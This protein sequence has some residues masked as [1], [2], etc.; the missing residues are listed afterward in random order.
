MDYRPVSADSHLEISTDQWIERVPEVHRD[1]APRRISLPNGGDAWLVE[2]MP[3]RICGLD[4]CGRPFE[5]FRITGVRYEDSAGAGDAVQ[6]VAEQDRDGIAAEI[7]FPGAG[8]PNF[9]RGI[10]N[11]ESYKAVLHAYNEFLVN[12]YV[13]VAPQRLIGLGVIPETGIEDAVAELRYCADAGL[14]GVCLN[15][16]PSGRSYPS[17]EDDAFWREAIDRQVAI[18]VHVVMRHMG[19]A[20]QGP[21]LGYEKRPGQDVTAKALDPVKYMASWAQGGGL[22]AAQ[23]VFAGTFD[24][25]PELKIYFAENFLGWI[26]QF[27][28]QLDMLYDRH[29]HWAHR[30][31]GLR[32]LDRR[33]SEFIREHVYYGFLNNPF[34]VKVRHEVGIDKVMWASDFPHADSDWPDSQ[35]VIKEIFDGVPEEEVRVMVRQNAVDYFHLED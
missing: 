35:R 28:E 34:G 10:A 16:W 9:W 20:R 19:G 11:D 7:L 18:T 31:F 27:Y 8:G 2:N 25:V 33:P 26:P 21:G 22:N 14:K 17:V 29:I 15:T 1:R 32:K 6:R 12:D 24:R 3:L 23:L 30:E 13:P 5:D 4:L